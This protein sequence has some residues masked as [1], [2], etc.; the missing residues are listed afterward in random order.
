MHRRTGSRRHFVEQVEGD[1][2]L[3]GDSCL[4]GFLCPVPDEMLID[5]LRSML[6][7]GGAAGDSPTSRDLSLESQGT[8]GPL[9]AGGLDAVEP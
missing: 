4:G 3:F 7:S 6:G 5:K 1:G 9:T 2:R 8:V